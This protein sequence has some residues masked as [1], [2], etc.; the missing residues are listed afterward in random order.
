[1]KLKVSVTHEVD[2]KWRH[3]GDVIDVDD[4]EARR[5]VGEGFAQVQGSARN[6]KDAPEPYNPTT[7][8]GPVSEDVEPTTAPTVAELKAIAKERDITI[9]AA[10]EAWRL[11]H[12]GAPSST[13]LGPT[14]ESDDKE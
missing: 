14:A 7:V 11:E 10:K 2:G 5:L 6:R 1:V 8:V 12:T 9:A 13:V 4:A 3:A